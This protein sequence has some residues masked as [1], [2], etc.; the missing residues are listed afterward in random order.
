M[1]TTHTQTTKSPG[2][3][4][5]PDPPESEPDDMTSAEHLSETGLHRHLKQFLGNPE[6]TIV[7]G[8]KYITARRGAE[9]R[10]PDLLVAFNVN[11]QSYRET[12]NYVIS[13]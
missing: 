5:L 4:R 7:P 9:I 8:E 12:N 3:F 13:V 2:R 10:Y 6:T 11:P 1:T